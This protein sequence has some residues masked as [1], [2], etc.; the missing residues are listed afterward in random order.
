MGK[1]QQKPAN[2]NILEYHE[3][4]NQNCNSLFMAHCGGV[5]KWEFM[6]GDHSRRQCSGGFGY[7]KDVLGN[8][9]VQTS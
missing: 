9:G 6:T 5:S 3:E 8:S 7:E 1:E 2:M 4:S